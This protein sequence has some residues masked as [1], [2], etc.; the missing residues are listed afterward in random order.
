MR[1]LFILFTALMLSGCGEPTPPTQPEP[2]AETSDSN[3][4]TR[5]LDPSPMHDSEDDQLTI[6]R[7]DYQRIEAAR[8]AGTLTKDS[9]SYYCEDAMTEGSIY[10]YSDDSG[11]VLASHGYTMGDHGG[12]TEYYYYHDGKF[13]FYFEQ[14]GYW[15]FGGPM[16]VLP[17]G[18]E[19]PGTIDKVIEKRRYY[20]SDTL[21]KAL[22]KTY[23][24]QSGEDGAVKAAE[25]TNS[26]DKDA[27]G[28]PAG[29][30]FMEDD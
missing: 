10:F 7:K 11:V 25:A 8:K 16:Q 3:P 23:E 29:K 1:L 17:D 15:Q 24:I 6:I 26:S 22:I 14:G 21:I 28:V 20:H 12:A 30:R 4:V 2:P 18:S 19:V 9:L 27:K 5:S 13:F